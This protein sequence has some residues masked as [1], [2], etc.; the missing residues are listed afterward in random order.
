MLGNAIYPYFA[1]R[2]ANVYASDIEIEP[3]EHWLRYL[4]A[5]DMD[6]MRRAF[7]A[8]QPD[9]VLHL[10]A[11]VDVEKC[12]LDPIE[13]KR[14]NETTAEIAAKLCNE[15]GVTLVYISTGGVFDG[16]KEGFY[17]EDD[18]P[19]PIMIYGSTKLDGEHRVRE[20]HRKH[21]IIRP[22]W[23]VGGGRHIDH[24]FVWLILK[25]IASKQPVVYAV[26]DKWGTPT[27]THDFAMNLFRLLDTEQYG[28]YHMV[29]KDWGTRYDVACEIVKAIGNTE[30]KVVPVASDHFSKEFFVPRPRSEMLQNRNL[31][32][33]QINLMRPW[34]IAVRD[35]IAR[36]YPDFIEK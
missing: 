21:Y 14:S 12:E 35:Y 18:E 27:Y 5:R 1:S 33:L 9:L 24:K 30:V 3:H 20:T 34:R 11:L 6:M 15:R 32:R 25:Q 13:A 16:T 19:N 31:E 26:N 7:D 10:A 22:G 17:T 36:E 4:D 28:T 23:M 2:C 8:F 29:C